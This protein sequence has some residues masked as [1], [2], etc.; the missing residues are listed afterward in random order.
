M[1]AL[2]DGIFGDVS[3]TDTRF[4]SD[5]PDTDTTLLMTGDVFGVVPSEVNAV[6]DYTEYTRFGLW[7]SE[8]IAPAANADDDPD[9]GQEQTDAANEATGRDHG[10]VCLQPTRQYRPGERGF[11]ERCKGLL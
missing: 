1:K 5:T 10:A 4:K 6:F 11:T 9:V 3:N 7:T 8:K 2:D